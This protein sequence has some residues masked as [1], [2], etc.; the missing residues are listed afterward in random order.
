[1]GEL[2]DSLGLGLESG[3][4]VMSLGHRLRQ[5]L[6]GDITVESL[7]VGAVDL[8][9]A[10]GADL[11]DDTV[12]AECATDEVLHCSDSCCADVIVSAGEIRY[13]RNLLTT[14]RFDIC[15]KF[16]WY[17]WSHCLE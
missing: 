4:T 7:V 17:F 2:G 1:V 11:L 6:D 16:T 8:S 13:G 5:H 14:G 3:E 15:R 9:H 10:A 12:V